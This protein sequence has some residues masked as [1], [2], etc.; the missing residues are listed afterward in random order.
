MSHEHP[1]TEVSLV[2]DGRPNLLVVGAQKAGTTLL[3]TRLARHTDIYLPSQKEMN[4]FTSPNWSLESTGYLRH[5]SRHKDAMY[6]LD[7]TPGYFWTSRTNSYYDNRKKNSHSIERAIFDFLGPET[8]ILI[9][10]RH[11]S[12]RAVSAFFHQFRMGRIGTHAR[13]R[14]HL[15]FQ[16][17]VDI[18]FYSEHLNN[19]L[20]VFPASS[21]KVVFLEEYSKDLFGHDLDIYKWL[22]LDP[23]LVDPG[24]ALKDNVN[25]RTEVIDNAIRL[26]SGINQVLTLKEKDSRFEKMAPVD[27]PIV[28]QQDLQTLNQIYCNEIRK[29]SQLFPKVS[30]LWPLNLSLSDF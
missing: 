13:I 23:L 29:M 16:G 12:R 3:A 20:D 8:R 18:G 17:I 30:S 9:I 24:A 26:R 7:A 25:F 6:R 14:N 21:I 1:L 19:Y 15:K 2:S 10:L 27:P 11:P 4:F 5:Y 28:E 22:G